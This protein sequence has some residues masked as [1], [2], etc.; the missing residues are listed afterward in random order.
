MATLGSR[1]TELA[2]RIAANTTR[3]NNYLVA[4]NLPTPSFDVDG[5]KDTLV[6]KEE[7][8]VEAARVAIID[9]TQQLRRLVLGPREYLMSYTHNELISQQAI[10]RFGIAHSFPVGSEASFAD[11]AAATPQLTETDVRKFVRHAI[12]KDI[13]IEPRPGVVAHNAVSR[14]LAEDPVIHDWVG[15]STDDLWQ[16]ASQTCAALDKWKG[17]QEPNETGFALANGGTATLYE[18]FSRE[19]KRARRFGNAMRS[20]T[21]GTGFE[22]SHVADNFPWGE[23]GNA[24]VVDVGGS[25]GFACITLANM[26]PSLSFVVQDLAPVVEAGRKQVPPELADRITFM[27]HDFLTEQPDDIKTLKPDVFFFRWIFHNWSDKYCVKILRSLIP[28]LKPGAKIV[29]NDNVPPG[30]GVMSKWQE[31]RFRSMDITM[32]ELQNS[33]ERELN[34]WAKIFQ[35]ADPR[36]R[37]QGGKLP[38]GANLWL[39]VAEWK[40]T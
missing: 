33:F 16:S 34:D 21:E 12:N 18:V 31:D 11:I 30:P 36:F 26:F 27:E 19:P 28:A 3:L 32:K 10:T 40:E 13:F 2:S 23:L 14:L 24:T 37:F 1:I 5:P 35:L 15:A 39:L 17:S 7:T 9:D 25:Q 6:P 8:M 20:F 29:I 4:H 38:A 22:L